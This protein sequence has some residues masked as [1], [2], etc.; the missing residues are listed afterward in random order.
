V[1]DQVI[2]D[3][4]AAA[5]HADLSRVHPLVGWAVMDDPPEYPGKLVAR[6]ITASP[7]EYVL[8][9]DSLPELRDQIPPG[10]ARSQRQPADPPNL[11]ELWLG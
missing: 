2:D 6:L 9:A 11:V 10:L 8:V 5:L 4:M 7:S 1:T 3:V